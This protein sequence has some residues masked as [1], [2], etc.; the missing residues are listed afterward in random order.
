M[1]ST[2]VIIIILFFLAG[3]A[4]LIESYRKWFLMLQPFNPSKD[5]IPSIFF[6]V[7]IPAR[8]EE[9][10]IGICLQSVLNQQYPR[11]LFEVIVADD[12]STDN[13]AGIVRKYQQEYR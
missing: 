9:A 10:Q 6:S 12:Y 5:S 13:T 2:F 8:N 3:H 11:D 1:I 4:F 7:I